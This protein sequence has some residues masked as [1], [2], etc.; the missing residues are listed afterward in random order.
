MVRHA[1][2]PDQVL[3]GQWDGGVSEEGGSLDS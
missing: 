1:L 3:P 2:A